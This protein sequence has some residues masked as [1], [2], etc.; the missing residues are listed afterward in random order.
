MFG[1]KLAGLSY[2]EVEEIL[3]ASWTQDPELAIE[4]ERR[5]S[6]MRL[7]LVN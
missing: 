4:Q 2:R 5:G 7:C 1:I 3:P 6:D